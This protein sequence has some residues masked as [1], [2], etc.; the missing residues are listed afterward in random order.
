MTL[1]A[2]IKFSLIK[3][4]QILLFFFVCFVFHFKSTSIYHIT[5]YRMSKK[6]QYKTK[7]RWKMQ[8]NIFWKPIHYWPTNCPQFFCLLEMLVHFTCLCT[9]YVYKG[10]W[11]CVCTYVESYLLTWH[12]RIT[13]AIIFIN[14]NILMLV[15]VGVVVVIVFVDIIAAASVIISILY[16]RQFTFFY[17]M[18][19]VVHCYSYVCVYVSFFF[20]LFILPTSCCSYCSKPSAISC[21]KQ[22]K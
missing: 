3:T 13:I 14:F 4:E 22:E 10:V 7:K 11:V 15:L 8:A 17:Q 20:F 12:I 5:E 6:K 1:T 16:S 18:F 19:T 2:S 21:L 9:S